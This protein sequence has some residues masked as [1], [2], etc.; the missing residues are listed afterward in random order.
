MGHGVNFRTLQPVAAGRRL[1]Y[2]TMTRSPTSWFLSL[3]LHMRE[4]KLTTA[5][6]P[7][8]VLTQVRGCPNL[9]RDS[10]ATACRSHLYT[11][12]G[13][14][15]AANAPDRCSAFVTLFTRPH[16]ILLVNERYDDSMWLLFRL[17]DWGSPPAISHANKR[18]H[19]AY[20]REAVPLAAMRE[21]DKA[22]ASTCMPDIWASSHQRF[23]RVHGAARAFDRDHP[24]APLGALAEQLWPPLV[25]VT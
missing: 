14:G 22:V 17:L 2:V 10:N 1:R 25:A 4:K 9:L 12:H 21:L 19:R 13:G 7:L 5:T 24:G 8:F 11:W 15:V 20:D 6:A 3:Y 16:N 18:D 23:E